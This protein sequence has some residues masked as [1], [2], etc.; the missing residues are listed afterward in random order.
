MI[1]RLLVLEGR[2]HV[3][4]GPTHWTD[5]SEGNQIIYAQ[6]TSEYE[7]FNGQGPKAICMCRYQA[8]RLEAL[9][10]MQ[11]AETD[12]RRLWVKIDA[13]SSAEEVGC[14]NERNRFDFHLSGTEQHSTRQKSGSKR[15]FTMYKVSGNREKKI[16][17][18]KDRRNAVEM[19]T[20]S[21]LVTGGLECSAYCSAYNGARENQ[22]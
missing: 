13:L 19:S 2:T 21:V 8:H 9:A 15:G 7:N 10:T 20:L 22:L 16:R 1:Y 4:L 5:P 14:L 11:F 18:S 3:K 17:G 12:D 6:S